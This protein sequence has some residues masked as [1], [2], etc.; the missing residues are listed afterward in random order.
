MKKYNFAV[1]GYGGM[2]SY[3]C[4]SIKEKLPEINIVGVLDVREDRCRAAKENGFKVYESLDELANDKSIDIV[5]VATP[6]NFHK[7]LSIAMLKSGKNVVCEKPVTMNAEELEE[8]IAV[9]NETGKHFSVHQ[10][11]RW[12]KDFVI[13]K[14]IVDDKI[15]GKPYIIE[16]RVQGSKRV[17]AG[18]RGCKMNGGGMVLDWGI[19]LL[20][21]IMW[22]I[23]SPVIGVKADLF[24]TYSTEVD[25][26]CRLTINFECGT[27]ALIEVSTN[28]FIN[29]PRWHM[30]CT[31]GTVVIDDWSAQGKIIELADDKD[32]GWSDEI[33]YTE[34]GPTRTMAPRPRETTREIALPDVSTDWS[35]FY[36]NFIAAIEGKEEPIVKVSESLRVMKVIDLLF[37]SADE[38]RSISCSI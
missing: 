34:A 24:K 28:C 13:I 35:N 12:D 36:R 7:D 1:I 23:K 14:K 3:H 17:L 4:S 33:V 32:L 22:M 29:Q 37:K 16:S 27:T 19:H 10:N 21:Q 26:N 20:D 38:G 6:N 15:I 8:I 30:Q 31:D 5:L 9:K 25:D 2:G 11:R 18:W